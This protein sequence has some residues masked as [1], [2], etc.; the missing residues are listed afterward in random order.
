MP[1][2]TI[3]VL[4]SLLALIAC[5]SNDP[6]TGEARSAA[7]T[8]VPSGTCPN[9][10]RVVGPEAPSTSRADVDGDGEPDPLGIALDRT[11]EIGCQAFLFVRI[12]TEIHAAPVW[13]QGGQTGL[14]QPSVSSTVEIDGEEGAEVVVLEAVGAS[15]EFVGVLTFTGDGLR[16][17]EPGPDLA[18]TFPSPEG[19]FPFGGSIGHVDGVDCVDG[20]GLVMSSAVP[21][22]RPSDLEGSVYVLER[23]FVAVDD[24]T[25]V[26][27]R[28]ERERLSLDEIFELPEF[29]GTPFASCPNA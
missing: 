18:S 28:T 19:L 15:T 20:G 3:A 25:L 5:S 16:R 17:L 13:E 7:P 27:E 1:P 23:R 26:K 9:E 14:T 21:G 22:N 12:G 2:R 10:R 8:L 11:A 6:D 24:A 29:S 4:L